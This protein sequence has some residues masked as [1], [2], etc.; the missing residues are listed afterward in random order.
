M[1]S[2]KCVPACADNTAIDRV[3][4]SELPLRRFVTD[5]FIRNRPVI[6]ERAIDDWPAAQWTFS[7]I[8]DHIPDQMVSVRNH[9]SGKLFDEQNMA[10]SM[11]R[12]M[13]HEF[14]AQISAG[15]NTTPLYLAQTS[16]SQLLPPPQRQ[17]MRFPYLRRYDYLARTNLWIGTPG[18]ATPAHFDFTHNFYMQIDGHKEITLFAP[19]DSEYLY[20]NPRFPVVSRVDIGQPDL[21]VFPEFSNACPLTFMIGP[22]DTVF[23]PAR[24]WHYIVSC[25]DNNIAINQWFLRLWSRN[26]TQAQMVPPLMA[27]TLSVL[28]GRN[29]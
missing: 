20:P 14:L 28:L 15:K 25:Y 21:N 11:S 7:N 22:G 9:A 27:H 17:V 24:W 10:Q 19:E 6:I 4:A 23:I 5:Y 8:H 13:L 1:I 2:T 16:L 3:R 26:L 29:R 18:L 12:V